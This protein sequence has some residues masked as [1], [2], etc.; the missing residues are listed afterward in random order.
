MT[1]PPPN[2]DLL[3]FLSAYAGSMV[4]PKRGLWEIAPAFSPCAFRRIRRGNPKLWARDG[5]LGNY[6]EWV[7]RRFRNQERPS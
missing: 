6:A 7:P 4:V 1:V 2:P 5:V 3:R